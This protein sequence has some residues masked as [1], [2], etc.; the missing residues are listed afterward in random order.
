[1]HTGVLGQEVLDRVDRMI[2]EMFIPD[3]ITGKAAHPVVDT[4]NVRFEAVDQV[5]ERFER[6]NAPTG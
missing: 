2:D 5:I 4:G 6:R 1:M 3:V